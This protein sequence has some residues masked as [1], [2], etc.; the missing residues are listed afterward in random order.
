MKFCGECA[1]PLAATCPSCGA[2]NPPENKFCGQCAAPLGTTPAAKFAAPE[3]YTPKHLAEKILTSKA[4]LEGERKQVTVLFADLKGSMELLADRDPEE[5]RKLLDPVLEHMMEAVHRYEGTV[6][7]VM[8]DGIMALFGA[9]L[10]HED[11]AVRACYAALRMQES[12]KRYA[13]GVRRAHAAVVKIRVGLNSGEVVVRAIGSD[14]HMDYTAVGQTT[15]L[16]ARMEQIADPGAI[17]ITPETL[18]LA[19]GYVEVKSL[20]PV[21]VKGLADAVEVYE[22]TGVGPARTR[23]Q[24]AS[25]R[26]L[27][28]FVGRD[29]EVEQL[30]RAQQ[31]AGSGRGQV[32]AIVGEAGVGKSR[33]FHEFTHSHRVQDWLILQSGSVSYGKATSYLAVIDLLKGY[34]KVH[35]RET[36][37][38]IREKVTGRLLT[39]ERALEPTLPAFLQLLDVPVDDAH[40]Q[41]L[42]PLQRRQRTLDAVKRLLLCESQLQPLLVIFEDLHWIDSETQALLNIIVE[43]LAA[44]RVLL[45]VNY[46]PEYSHNWGGKSYYS[47]IRLD[48]LAPRD[49]GELLKTLIGQDDSLQPIKALLASKTGGNPLFLEESIRA[50]VEVKVL[51]GEPGAFQL[52]RPVESVQI[53]ATVRA[54]LASRIDRLPPEEKQLLQTA[55]VI[56]KDFSFALL[57][58]IAQD[59]DE[60]LRRE[61]SHLQ[62]AEFL[63]E[64]ALF[65]ELEYTF[66]HALTQ[67]VAYSSL[68]QERRR[69]LHG[70]VLDALERLTGDRLVERVEV[71]AHHASRAADWPRAARHQYRAGEKALAYAAFAAAAEFFV[72]SIEALDHQ[73]ETADGSLRLDAYSELW[74]TMIETGHATTTEFRTLADKAD[75]LAR[76]LGGEA[77]LARVRLQYAQ[78]LWARSREDGGLETALQQA[79]EAVTLSPPE[80]LRTRSYARL[81][82]GS[83]CHDLG[84]FGAA[85]IEFD[86]GVAL[87]STT[88]PPREVR[89]LVLPILANLYA[90][91]ADTL[92]VRGEFD[93]AVDSAKEALLAGTRLTHPTCMMIAHSFLGYVSLLR[94]HVE[95]ALP[96]FEE[97]L[98]LAEKD[99]LLH[100]LIAN[101]HYLGYALTLL[102]RRDEGRRVLIRARE[103]EPNPSFNLN[104]TKYRA[105][106][107]SAYLVQ[108]QADRASE[109]VERGYSLAMAH[110]ARGY[111]PALLRL[112]AEVALR[113]GFAQSDEATQSLNTGRE[114]A[115][116]LEMRPEEARLSLTQALVLNRR[117]ERTPARRELEQAAVLLRGLDMTF[118]LESAR[119]ELDL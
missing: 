103:T 26:G 6:N 99:G 15:H 91:R 79:R 119:K 102:G 27:T 11:H 113:N 37:R 53:S 57:E 80:D 68:L 32:A 66:K 97:A 95:A 59:T 25:R 105:V 94:G 100:G 77:R 88:E 38:G 40:W 82:A 109:E 108:G 115:R 85:L 8:G 104:W 43:S 31:L 75:R 101:G 13:E 96:H 50:L 17:V 34:F 36:H 48:A 46:R 20:G 33:L 19:E 24:A 70:R 111:L 86:E 106:V 29:A 9:P 41:A 58:A 61:L 23:L 116:Q 112:R 22:L 89:G 118:W 56:G 76:Q 55:A 35:D 65:P 45:L 69:V 114:I 2:A 39:L 98:A 1:A 51:V 7:Q 117:G 81:L 90:W 52:I 18:A 107:A 10:A 3:S 47:Q 73:G 110:N 63:Y 21:P 74:V 30:R 49:A 16:A 12:V 60:E 78:F 28:R 87:F 84:R 5:A 44:A 83:I 14:L 93:R 72:R 42:D 67:E 92:A 4:A 71:L 64:T 62:H 54:I